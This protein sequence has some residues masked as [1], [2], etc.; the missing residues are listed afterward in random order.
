MAIRQ[1]KEIKGINIVKEE[2]KWSLFVDDMIVYIKYGTQFTKR[3]P[4]GYAKHY[5]PPANKFPIA[6]SQNKKNK[7]QN[8]D[9]TIYFFQVQL[10]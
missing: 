2:L 1:V 8:K 10:S 4:N 6:V 7:K 9:F 5:Y 3:S